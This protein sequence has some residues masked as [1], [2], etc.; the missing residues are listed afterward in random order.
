M[1]V[2]LE[3]AED[4][5]IESHRQMDVREFW[6]KN[7]R[8][9]LVIAHPP[10][11]DIAVSGA[12]FFAKKRLDGRVQRGLAMAQ[13]VLDLNCH[14]IVMENPVSLISSHIRK[15]D[16]VIQPNQFGHPELKTTCLWLINVPKLVPVKNVPGRK[17]VG[18]RIGH[19]KDRAYQRAKTYQGIADAFADQYGSLPLISEPW[20]D[21]MSRVLAAARS[22]LK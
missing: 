5:E 2:D 12:Q 1:S 10:C 15:P 6:E 7:S 21:P 8:F 14:R 20:L 22:F 13:W 9:D 19:R 4:G 17:Q 11:T 3:A 18:W 16:Q